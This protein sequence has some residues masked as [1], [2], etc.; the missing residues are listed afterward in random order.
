VETSK[1]IPIASM[2]LQFHHKT[3][4]QHF[5][6]CKF[7]KLLASRLVKLLPC[8][9]VQNIVTNVTKL[10]QI[11]AVQ[12]KEYCML[13]SLQQFQPGKHSSTNSIDLQIKFLSI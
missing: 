1:T 13:I 11:Q 3:L 7:V 10:L 12:H 4:P 5:L 6:S 2:K 9:H 8:K